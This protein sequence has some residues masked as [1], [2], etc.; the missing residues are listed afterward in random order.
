MLKTKPTTIKN[1]DTA[2]KLIIGVRQNGNLQHFAFALCLLSCPFCL[3]AK[4]TKKSRQT[5]CSAALPSL[6]SPCVT[7]HFS[8]KLLAWSSFCSST[9]FLAGVLAQFTA[10][11]R[12]EI[13]SSIIKAP[14]FS[15]NTSRPLLAFVGVSPTKVK[16]IIALGW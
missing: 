4:G 13:R 1:T 14:F 8:C 10:A 3:D 9:Y 16:L 12:C 6:A 15:H 2:T 11:Y 5:R 7:A